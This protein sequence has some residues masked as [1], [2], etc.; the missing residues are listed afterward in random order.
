MLSAMG[1]KRRSSGKPSA[2]QVQADRAPPIAILGYSLC[3]PSNLDIQGSELAR[4]ARDGE[5]TF[6]DYLESGIL[7]PHE[8]GEGDPWRY[9]HR[10]GNKFRP[11][12]LEMGIGF[13][14]ALLQVSEKE[15]KF[16]DTAVGLV[17]NRVWDTLETVGI[18]PSLLQKTRTGIFTCAMKNFGGYTSYPDETALRSGLNSGFSD[19]IAYFLG[20]H[21]PTL[22][23]ETA[24]SSSLVA[25]TLAV[26]AIRDGS[27]D[28][29]IITAI[30]VATVEYELSLQA[31]GVISKEGQCRP[32]ADD[33]SGTL[34]CEGEACMF[35]CSMEW[36][37]QNGY[38]DTIK[39]LVVNSAIGSAGADPKAA[40]GSGRIYE[41]PNVFGMAEMIRLCH[42]QVG[43][44]LGNIS[45]IEA[46]ATGTKVG[47]LV[48]LEALGAVYGD[49]HDI[50]RNPLRVGSIKGNIGHAELAAG[51]FSLIKA[52]EMIRARTFFPTGGRDITPRADFDWAANSV[53]LCQEVEPF[54]PGEQCYIGVNSF[55]IGGSYAHTIITEYVGDSD[56]DPVESM[57]CP[58]L[59]TLSAASERHLVLYEKQILEYLQASPGEVG[60]LDLCG[61]FALNRARLPCT[62][63]YIVESID[64]LINDLVSESKTRVSDGSASKLAVAMVFTGQGSQWVGMGSGLMVF[65]AFRDVATRFDA[66][67]KRLSGWS[68]LDKLTSLSDDQMD[69]TMYAQP[70]TFMVQVG[71]VELLAYLGV[72]ADVVVGHSAG[73]IAALYCC[74][75]LSLED[76]AA[77]VW[78][79]SRCQQ[80]VAGNGRMLAIQL[81]SA[82]AKAILR[83]PSLDVSSCEIA[84]VNS[85]TSVVMAGP[86]AELER[87]RGYLSI[88]GVKSTFLK[89]STA[90]HCSLMDPILSEVD[91]RLEF[92]NR[93]T[94]KGSS[95]VTFLST[96]SSRALTSVTSEYFVHNIRQPVRF[97]ETI[98]LLLRL[99][100]P[101]VVLELG[102]HK[103]LAPLLSECIQAASQKARVLS[104]LSKGAEDVACFWN[105]VRGLT[106][107]GVSV[108]LGPVYTD[109]G[110][111]FRRVEEK[112]I[113]RH[114][115]IQRV[116]GDK[117]IEM[118]FNYVRGMRDIGPAAGTLASEHSKLVSM[119]EISKATSSSMAEHVMGGMA[120]LPGAY[121]VEAAIETWGMGHDACLSMTDV[122]FQDMCPIPDR[123]QNEP[124]NLFVRHSADKSSRFTSFT[125]DSRP[126]HSSDTTVHCTGEMASFARPDS[127]DG[128]Q[129]M[130][131][132]K[133]TWQKSPVTR[134]IGE[135]G[136]RKLCA[137]HQLDLSEGSFYTLVNQE[138]IAHYGPSFQVV[139]EVRR[140]FDGSS[141]VASLHFGHDQ[142]SGRG[143]VYGVQLLD[144]IFQ[145]CYLNPYMTSG[146]VVYAGGFDLGLFLRAPVENPCFVHMQFVEDHDSYGQTVRQGDALM[147]DSKG[148]VLCHLI[149]I[150]SIVG[151]RAPGVLDA[152]P[153]WQPLSM[154]PIAEDRDAGAC[155]PDRSSAV[156]RIIAD[157]LRRKHDLVRGE[158]CYLRVLECWDDCHSVPSVFAALA[159]VDDGV[160][161]EFAFLVEV[162]VGTHDDGVMKRSYV[163]PQKHKQ[164]LKLRL[165]SLPSGHM[166]L[167]CYNFCFDVVSVGARGPWK[168][169]MEFLSFAS[170]LGYRGSVILHDF[171]ID[172]VS[173]LWEGY[174]GGCQEHPGGFSSGSLLDRALL[175]ALEV[176]G[177]DQSIFI[178]SKDVNL[179]RQ[180]CAAFEKVASECSARV[181]VSE[182][183]IHFRDAEAIHQ[184][185]AEVS[186]VQGG[187]RHVVILDGVVDES[188]YT[189][190]TF[191]LS[192]TIARAIGVESSATCFLWLVASNAFVPPINVHRASLHPLVGEMAREYN[193]TLR[194]KYVDLASPRE[195][196][197][198]LASL[199]L[200]RPGPTKFMIDVDGV[201]HQ[202]LLLPREVA[203]PPRRVAVR[204]DD[205][206]KF[207]KLDLVKPNRST[208]RQGGYEFFAHQVN[209]PEAGE[210][211][212]DI[213]YASLNFRDV[214]LTL[215]A[216]PRSS[217]EASFYTWHL[218]MEA[219]GTIAEVGPGV[220][221]VA[222]GDMV[223]VS[224]RGTIA[225]KVTVAAGNVLPLDSSLPMKEAA[226]V[227]S[228]YTT[229]YH[230]LIDLCRLRKG[231]R[232]LVH[233]AAGGVGHAAISVC[234]YIGTYGL[235][236]FCF[237][238]LG[239]S[240]HLFRACCYLHV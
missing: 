134:D 8:Y 56:D 92:L 163:I 178:V 114:P 221:H 74:G 79:R 51:L 21:G 180:L 69:H 116:S 76:A 45:Y 173:K 220:H 131:G 60:L 216:L 68:P 27:C 7:L 10:V 172:Q 20:T 52:V 101:G 147:Y 195:S 212:V 222:P 162:F 105:L 161:P 138:G 204:A 169:P 83:D 37:I 188:E 193:H 151:K 206:D 135:D 234:R 140:N 5:T 106:E 24:C 167:D 9:Q 65:R 208:G 32:F 58:L 189:S 153:V 218:G 201:V 46:H 187:E 17:M 121:Y 213:Q 194:P 228:V 48:E 104:S 36:A 231:D 107:A 123:S 71:L 61:L 67:Y 119:V 44:P 239:S 84:C 115:K 122:T 95:D 96:V 183:S 11:G 14:H 129:Y 13:D 164:W 200:S 57:V 4:I 80:A 77:V 158:A 109:M 224:A 15:G 19:R 227:S 181:S 132:V 215:N 70:L 184:L 198:A 3:L 30:N 160:M 237:L 219:A 149:G 126:I 168:D 88:K 175:G 143:G 210:V 171:D 130:P 91:A 240:Q 59:L 64:G 40:Q 209:R 238:T 148:R 87:V 207:Y 29:A 176:D 235:F 113:P 82:D 81:G 97:C 85:P 111:R 211:L 142:W 133:G 38:S 47:D 139:D 98:D 174:V 75:L 145:L 120:I 186:C 117:W 22:A 6:V 146:F 99:Y 66:L 16:M 93:R 197:E 53:Q 127:F 1:I 203:R 152:V 205:P 137:A 55:G 190:D 102:P 191:V 124:R 18:P 136:I 236:C 199:I 54:P 50:Q 31:T 165:V 229:A 125:V 62:R 89:G 157:V 28:T 34:R 154:A 103:T 232:V 128:S 226:C 192:A 179:S 33:A 43:L 182:R 112:G 41:S 72:R 225:S 144:G 42:E 86:Q 73:E 177:F 230:A 141:V 214:M 108:D 94:A 78:H 90:F 223:M 39:C 23:F 202:R 100:E 196:P 233:A 155:D 166:T 170:R 12:D 49:S 159:S 110:Y 63:S 118:N 25:L 217:M 185:A 26:N 35:V 150:N 156:A 2:I